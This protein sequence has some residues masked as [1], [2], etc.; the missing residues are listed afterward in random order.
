MTAVVYKRA[1]AERDLIEHYVCLAEL[2]GMETADRFLANADKSF[3]E[4]SRYPGLGGALSP[5]S[6]RLAGLRK[7]Q[8]SGFEN[9][10]IFYMPRAAGVTILRVLH[11]SRDWWAFRESNER[12]TGHLSCPGR[13]SRD[14]VHADAEGGEARTGIFSPRRSTTTTRARRK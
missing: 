2:A 3:E 1:S 14:A 5:R 8:V 13:V 6:A 12:S 10:L 7:W 9:V 11:A 4:L